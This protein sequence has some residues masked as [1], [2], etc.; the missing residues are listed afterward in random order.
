MTIAE[1][2]P[3]IRKG[4]DFDEWREAWFALARERGHVLKTDS[5]FGGVDQFVTDGGYCNG[6]GC[7]KCGW[8]ECYHCDWNGEKIP[9]CSAVE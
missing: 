7:V 6:P 9:Q 3:A 5:D 4:M 8:T 2:A 1:K